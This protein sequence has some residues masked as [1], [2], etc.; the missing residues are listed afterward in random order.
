MASTANQTA[1]AIKPLSLDKRPS[2][3]HATA[4]TVAQPPGGAVR[5]PPDDLVAVR[6][7]LVRRWPPVLGRPES[8]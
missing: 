2:A 8:P 5:H 7:S 6:P 3:K 1:G 4:A